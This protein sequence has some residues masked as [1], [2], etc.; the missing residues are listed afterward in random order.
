MVL[1]TQQ[2]E[3]CQRLVSYV[4]VGVEPLPR[5]SPDCSLLSVRNVP[6]SLYRR[7]LCELER[8]VN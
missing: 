8:T 2:R 5:M 1:T 7:I 6:Y 3:S 4:R